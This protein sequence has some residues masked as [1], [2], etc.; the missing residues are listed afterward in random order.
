MV[1]VKISDRGVILQV[2]RKICPPVGSYVK[3]QGRRCL[4]L[5]VE[6]PVRVKAA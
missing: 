4:V 1:T 3:H 6:I 5:A 2:E